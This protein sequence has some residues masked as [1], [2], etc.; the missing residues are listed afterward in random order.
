[1]SEKLERLRE[2][3]ERRDSAQNAITVIDNLLDE[4]ARDGIGR[5]VRVGL[6]GVRE[7][8]P[9]PLYERGIVELAL[10]ER[11]EKHVSVRDAV[12]REIEGMLK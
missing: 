3:E 12:D 11:R 7:L 8:R 5:E 6:M 1:M 2:A 10:G 9:L 4:L